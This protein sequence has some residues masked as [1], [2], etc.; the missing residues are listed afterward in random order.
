MGLAAIG[1]SVAVALVA[2]LIA[3][4]FTVTADDTSGEA[5][6]M[7]ALESRLMALEDELK[8][9]RSALESSEEMRKS[10]VAPADVEAGSGLD[11]FLSGLQIGG[12]VEASYIYNWNNPE[13]GTGTDGV[14]GQPGVSPQ[15]H[16]QFNRNHN[17]FE[18]DAVKF[19][20]G[21]PAS[22][23]G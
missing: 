10:G 8:A 3:V 13:Q 18:L 16:F 1:K 19:E 23:P 20:I 2:T 11:S 21:K 17:T 7:E 9:T 14:G 12:Y 6:R 15:P 22:E 4:P 5:Q